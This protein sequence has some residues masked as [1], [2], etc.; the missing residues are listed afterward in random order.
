M[1]NKNRATLYTNLVRGV[2]AL[3][4]IDGEFVANLCRLIPFKPRAAEWPD[5]ATLAP[6]PSRQVAQ[7]RANIEWCE[8]AI[9][10]YVEDALDPDSGCNPEWE[11]TEE[12][13]SEPTARVELVWE[14]QERLDGYRAKL[15]AA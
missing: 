6:L 13:A 14:L 8:D 12:E 10:D 9:R 4:G 3:D 15:S 11:I 5:K 7:L 1:K 2:Y